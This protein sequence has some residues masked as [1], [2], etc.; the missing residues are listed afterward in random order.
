M[1][2]KHSTIERQFAGAAKVCTAMKLCPVLQTL[3]LWF[4]VL[5]EQK[6][7]ANQLKQCFIAQSLH[8]HPSIVL[9]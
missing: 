5:L 8:Y 4:H 1:V 2:K 9:I 3:G 7:F 6:F